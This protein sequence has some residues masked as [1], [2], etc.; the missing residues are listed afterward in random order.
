MVDGHGICVV[1][2][3]KTKEWQKRLLSLKEQIDYWIIP[4]MATY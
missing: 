2:K 4:N 1:K 3:T